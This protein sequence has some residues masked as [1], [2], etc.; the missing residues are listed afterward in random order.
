MSAL[1]LTFLRALEHIRHGTFHLVTPEGR[2]YHFSGPAAGPHA[3]LHLKT[4]DVIRNMALRGDVALAEDYRDGKWDSD[5]LEGLF[6]NGLQNE[7]ALD[8]FIYGGVFG[9]LAARAMTFLRRN[10]R[11]GSRRNIAAHYDLGNAFYQEWLDPTMTYSAAL[12]RQED[13]P[14][15]SAQTNKY[16]R[17]LDQL[18]DAPQGGQILEVGCGWGG[19]AEA[20]ARAGHGVHGITLSQE[21]HRYAVE[22]LHPYGA[23]AQVALTDYRDQQGRF[24]HLVSIEMFEAVGERY[25]PTYFQ[26]V[27]SLL[28]TKGRAVIQTITIAEPYFERYRRGGDAIRTFIFPGGMLPSV[29]RFEHT[30]RAAGLAVTNPH[31]F[32]HDYARTLRRWLVGFEAKAGTLK[33]MGYDERFQRLWRY[34]LAS[35]AASFQ[36]GRTDVYQFTLVRG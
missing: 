16:Q 5:H 10:T 32:G 23:T 36:V 33:G 14:L 4:W 3:H 11:Q 15:A 12:F 28:H 9:R 29:S 34:Y 19:F 27:A 35:C 17:I 25:W 30:A 6:L 18:A 13:E 24:D 1:S 21:Q 8:S 26:K 20:A 7:Q 22:R 31:A 2:D